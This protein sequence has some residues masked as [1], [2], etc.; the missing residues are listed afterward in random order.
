[1]AR[2]WR[3]IR[4]LP[5][6]RIPMEM[7]AASPTGR[8]VLKMG[9][10]PPLGMGQ[11]STFTTPKT[12]PRVKIV[13]NSSRTTCRRLQLP[14]AQGEVPAQDDGFRVGLNFLLSKP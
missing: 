7:P 4:A 6:A 2:R 3:H 5:R 1:M 11:N 9:D 8:R 13:R 14:A 12:N 10:S